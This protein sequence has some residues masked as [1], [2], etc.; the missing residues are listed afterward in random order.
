MDKLNAK[1]EV[2][3]LKCFSPGEVH[4]PEPLGHSCSVFARARETDCGTPGALASSRPAQKR[5]SHRHPCPGGMVTTRGLHAAAL[6]TKI[7]RNTRV[8]RV[9]F[10]SE[11][12]AKGMEVPSA[13][14]SLPQGE[15]TFPG[16]M[17]VGHV[18]PISVMVLS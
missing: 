7:K 6:E 12:D 5:G 18:C 10:D 1:E 2:S 8:R 11:V 17:E 4:L 15:S 14:R 3:S 13:L 16:I 9:Q